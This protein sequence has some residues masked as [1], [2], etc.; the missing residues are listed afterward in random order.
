MKQNHICL[1]QFEQSECFGTVHTQTHTHTHTQ[2]D[3]H[4]THTHTHT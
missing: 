3:T 4:N 1:L 2:R